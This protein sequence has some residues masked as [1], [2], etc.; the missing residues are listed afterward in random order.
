MIR[1][2]QRPSRHLAPAHHAQ[3]LSPST[4]TYGSHQETHNSA[5][6]WSGAGTSLAPRLNESYNNLTA[7]ADG[8][9]SAHSWNN[10]NPHSIP[11]GNLLPVRIREI[12]AQLASL[13]VRESAL[14]VRIVLIICSSC[15]YRV[16]CFLQKPC[17]SILCSLQP[18]PHPQPHPN[19]CPHCNA[20]RRSR[21]A[22]ASARPSASRPSPS[23][24]EG[25]SAIGRASASPSSPTSCTSN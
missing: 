25:S 3:L 16:E 17:R 7:H 24:T 22:T 12:E 11:E 23:R 6:A 15:A 13:L 4:N 20:A 19:P 8:G 10:L 5:I 1:Y 2:Q 14:R 21:S 18:Q 9:K